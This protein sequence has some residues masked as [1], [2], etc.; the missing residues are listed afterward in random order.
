MHIRGKTELSA[1]CIQWGRWDIPGG[2]LVVLHHEEPNGVDDCKGDGSQEVDVAHIVK[3]TK[4]SG[5]AAIKCL[6]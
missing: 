6:D 1:V 2:L 5:G 4:D 3:V